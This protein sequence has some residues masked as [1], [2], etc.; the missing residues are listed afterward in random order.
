MKKVL[1]LFL[2]LFSGCS[3]NQLMLW[4]EL[5]KVEVL[6]QTPYMKHYRVYFQRDTLKPIRNGKRYLWFYNRKTK[7]LAILLHP[8]GSYKLYNI[9]HPVLIATTIP[10]D[11]RHG[12]YH[13]LRTLKSKG[14]RRATPSAYGFSTS[15]VPRRYKG[16]KT[17]RVDVKD[18]RRL[19]AQYKLA[20]R[21]YNAKWIRNIKTKLPAGLIRTYYQ[22]YQAKAVTTRQKQQLHIIGIKLGINK[23]AHKE[24]QPKEEPAKISKTTVQ[25]I[26]ESNYLP[27]TE[28]KVESHD[29]Y[30]YYLKKASYYELQNYLSTSDAKSTLSYSQY[31]TLTKRYQSLKEER[32][33]K[34][35]SL[36]ELIAAYKKNNDPRYKSKIMTRIK[37][38]QKRS[39]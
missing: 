16:V 29:T 35:G 3:V 19:I 1:L 8:K 32:L 36:E 26:P 18:Y 24:E 12:Y 31:N 30:T 34:E 7:D 11:R 33:L 4:T 2:F 20:I 28:K 37:E 5:N 6:K 13:L 14:F 17:Y 27:Q 25:D 21:T 15:I 9:T 22:K 23:P 39:R 10:A 38:L